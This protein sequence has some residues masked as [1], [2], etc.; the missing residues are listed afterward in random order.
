[1]KNRQNQFKNL[2][3]PIAALL[4]GGLVISVANI[5]ALG[6]QPTSLTDFHAKVISDQ[7]DHSPHHSDQGGH[8][9][10]HHIADPRSLRHIGSGGHKLTTN[11]LRH[12]AWNYYVV[13]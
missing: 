10:T 1:M 13:A 3:K 6:D 4:V 2:R 5:D 12:N 7:H 8:H 9:Y 11:D